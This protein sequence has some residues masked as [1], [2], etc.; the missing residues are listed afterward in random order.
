MKKSSIPVALVFGL[1]ITGITQAATVNALVGGAA[2][3][4]NR[5]NFDSLAIGVHPPAGTAVP[6]FSPLGGSVPTV[7]LA[8]YGNGAVVSGS[9]S[10]QYAA[11]HLSGSNGSMFGSDGSNL[12][13]GSDQPDGIDVTRYVTTGTSS[14]ELTFS[15]TQL[16]LG[17]LWG[18]VDDYNTLEFYRLGL[19]VDSVTGLD[20]DAAADGDQ[21]EQGT[22]Y[23]NINTAVPFDSVLFKSSDFAFEFDNVAFS[24]R[25]FGEEKPV[26]DGGTTLALLG[27]SIGGLTLLRRKAG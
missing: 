23:V 21:G 10:S 6:V 12:P 22:F 16:Y 11:P 9:V 15:E 4:A 24:Q 19:L 8:T 25:P 2:T 5:I 1:G 17:L 18:S 3:G 13:D 27:A 20:V 7:T 14:V 26:P